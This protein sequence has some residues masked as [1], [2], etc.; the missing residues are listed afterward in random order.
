MMRFN[1]TAKNKQAEVLRDIIDADSRQHAL[2][3]LRKKD[4]TV[5]S[6]TDKSAPTA[7][8][9]TTN[10]SENKEKETEEKQT[11]V[12]SPGGTHKNYYIEETVKVL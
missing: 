8:N 12:Q 2:S 1:Y 10:G 6:L 11:E 7:T 9:G 5:V 4:L 3:Q